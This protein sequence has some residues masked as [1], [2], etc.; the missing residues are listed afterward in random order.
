MFIKLRNYQDDAWVVVNTDYIVSIERISG[1]SIITTAAKNDY[2]DPKSARTV[3]YDK[4][5]QRVFTCEELEDI[6]ELVSKFTPIEGTETQSIPR[7]KS[8]KTGKANSKPKT[9]YEDDDK[10]PF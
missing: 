4:V 2:K 7:T 10:I 8:G 6:I 1:G 5:N 9:K 3:E